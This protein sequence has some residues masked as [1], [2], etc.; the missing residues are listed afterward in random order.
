[1]FNPNYPRGTWREISRAIRVRNRSY[2][3]MGESHPRVYMLCVALVGLCAVTF[4]SPIV[5]N[6]I[7]NITAWMQR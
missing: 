1:M 2:R 5:A 6:W 4:L 7:K 3:T